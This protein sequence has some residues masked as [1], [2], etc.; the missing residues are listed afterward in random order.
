MDP[1]VCPD[2]LAERRY[3]YARAA[4]AEGD[5]R[6]AGELL[7]QALELAPGWAPAWFALGAA[8]EQLGELPGACAAYAAA[9]NA[10]PRD[11]LGA[12]PRLAQLENR[13]VEAL[14][15]AYVARLFDDYAPRFERHLTRSLGYCGP[16]VILAALDSV[17]PGR[18][19]ARALDLGCGS[20]LAGRA[21]R[22]RV[23]RLIG[24]DISAGM[25]AQARATG[26]YDELEVGDLAAFLDG[27]SGVDLA[28][29][30]DA[31]VYLGD[32]TPVFAAAA[33]A[34]APSG[35]LVFTIES[36]EASFALG[37]A[38]RFRHSD[39][40]VREAAQAAGLEIAHFVA[41]SVRSEA[42]AGAPGR[43]AA[44]AKT[45]R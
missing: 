26:I 15:P 4:A 14:P 36:G 20:G 2:P 6:T 31:F 19:F 32:L 35:L 44:L 45:G 30:A 1:L 9:L 10:D 25:I 38:M 41:A 27:R 12:G 5:A 17:A 7:E 37:P 28:V 42:G 18:R 16:E 39:A 11:R 13:R 29:A 21:L 22:P 8:R 3:A 23:E 34:L 43:V 40:H 33:K 24:V